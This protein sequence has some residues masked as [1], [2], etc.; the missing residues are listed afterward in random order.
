MEWMVTVNEPGKTFLMQGNEA[1][2]RGAL[3]AGVRF[4]AAYPGSPSSEILTMLG[5]VADEMNLYAEWSTN[6]NCAFQACMGASFGG[7]RAL[8]VVKQN[9]LL[10]IGD[11]L[12]TAALSG[13]K[14]GVVLLTADD[15]NAHSSTNEFDSRHQARA[16]GIPL[17]EPAT[18][19]EAKDMIVYGFE[20]SEKIGQVVMVRSVTRICHGR[21]NVT[22]GELPESPSSPVPI[23]EWDKLIAIN[24]FHDVLW[25]KLDQAQELFEE[26]PFNWYSGPEQPELLIITSGTGWLYSVEAVETLGLEDKVGILKL[27]C[28]WPLPEKLV[29]KYLR[30]SPRVLV[31]E[32]V[33]P[34]LEQNVAN[35][36]AHNPG[37]N[38]QLYGRYKRVPCPSLSS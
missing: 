38:V 12:H 28:T 13:C 29:L 16:A 21:G 17:L 33:D 36:I 34:F 20:L 5:H 30:K 31:V 8:C 11:A 25:A 19:Q 26:S 32:E 14:G 37:L 4:A 27:G 7:V 1:I 23:G 15:P 6:E 10:T 18:F 22:L 24:W 9:G 2:V 35:I 3:E